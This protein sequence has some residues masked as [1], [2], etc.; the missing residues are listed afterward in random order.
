MKHAAVSEFA[1]AY[2]KGEERLVVR[3]TVTRSRC[4]MTEA[5]IA[6]AKCGMALRDAK[7]AVEI[8]V[9][10]EEALLFLPQVN[11]CAELS[12]QLVHAGF[13]TEFFPH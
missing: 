10:S 3:R 4:N 1:D 12:D 6:I 11:S 2:H 13:A 8:A 5:A 7:R 9:N